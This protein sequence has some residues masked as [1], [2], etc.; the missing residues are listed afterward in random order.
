MAKTAI[1]RGSLRGQPPPTVTIPYA[2]AV[3]PDA[4]LASSVAVTATGGLTVNT[5]AGGRIGQAVM[6]AIT[7]SGANRAVTLSGI[8]LMPDT[9]SPYTVTAGKTGY[10]GLFREA[11]GSWRCM[12]QRTTP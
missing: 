10:L 8:G 1:G 4:S 11:G 7:A 5:P 2:S 6:V 9:V 3:T 12:W